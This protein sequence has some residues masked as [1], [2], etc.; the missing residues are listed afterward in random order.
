MNL[1][2]AYL[3]MIKAFPGGW[4]AMCGALGMS[5]DSLENRIYERKGQDVGV[6]T[7]MLMQSFTETTFFADAVCALSGGTFSKLPSV[8]HISNEEIGVKF[9]ELYEELGMLSQEYREDTK[10]GS[11]NPREKERFNALV[12]KIHKTMDELRALTFRVYCHETKRK[13]MAEGEQV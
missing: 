10:N 2:Q 8:E 13:T 1:R 5:R 6:Q 11:I 3:R 12:D 7:A 4:D 9:H